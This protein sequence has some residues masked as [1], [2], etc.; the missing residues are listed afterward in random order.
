[1]KKVILFSLA[2]LLGFSTQAQDFTGQ[3]NGMLKVPNQELR[4]VFKIK[5]EGKAYIA[6]M[7]SPDQGAK[8][9]PTSSTEVEGNTIIIKAA[10]MGMTYTGELDEAAGIIKGT[11]QQGVFSTDLN[12]SRKKVLRKIIPRAQ[13]PNDFPYQQ[14]AVSFENQVAQITLAGTLTLPKTKKIKKVVVLISGSGAQDRNSDLGS[15]NHRP[16]LV[17][18]DY[19]T[20]EGIAVLRYDERGVGESTGKYAGAT[21]LD[22]SYDVEAAV[23]YLKSRKD[24]KRAKIGLIGHS[25]G[26]LIAPMLAARNKSI[27]FVVLLAG[28]GIPNDELMILQARRMAEAQGVPKV[29]LDANGALVSDAYTF[30]KANKSLEDDDFKKGI[31]EVFKSSIKQNFPEMVQQAMGDIDTFSAKESAKMTSPWF[32]YFIVQNPAKNLRKLKIP[33][34]AMNGTLDMQ[35]TA[36]ENLEGMRKALSGNKKARIESLEGLNHLFQ[37][38]KTGAASE[39]KIIEETFNESA[40]KMI[41]DWVCKVR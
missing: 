19:L 8:D 29:M 28:P 34:L 7:D 17:L 22:F 2:F 18:S 4:L 9:L 30:M 40:L 3:W 1:M 35:V 26:G 10:S 24:M 39:Y 5:K 32:R 14:E 15:L 16:F 33:V 36:P 25:E 21:S 41:G 6:T 37:K 38:A 31:K 23:A 11:F 20:R 12:L 27:D 13:E